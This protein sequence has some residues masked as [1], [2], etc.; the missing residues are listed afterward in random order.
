MRLSLRS[1]VVIRKMLEVAFGSNM[2]PDIIA[3][4][5]NVSVEFFSEMM[6]GFAG[7]PGKNIDG[8]IPQTRPNLITMK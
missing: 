2:K 4:E 6:S 8:D 7:G 1:H 5:F 3:K